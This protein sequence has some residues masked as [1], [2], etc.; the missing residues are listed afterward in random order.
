MISKMTLSVIVFVCCVFAAAP[1]GSAEKGGR[2]R[3]DSLAC[4]N[5]DDAKKYFDLYV[6]HRAAARRFETAHI[7]AK[8]CRMLQRSTEVIIRRNPWSGRSLCVTPIGDS[9]CL[10]VYRGWINRL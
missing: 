1:A 7:A 9:E 5:R 3:Y 6:K 8:D 4:K 2:L 10:W